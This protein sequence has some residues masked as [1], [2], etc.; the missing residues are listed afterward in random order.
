M[1]SIQCN[2]CKHGIHY[3]SIP[4]GT[5]YRFINIEN[6]QIICNSKFEKSNIKIDDSNI[7]PKLYRSDTIEED[8]SDSIIKFWICPFCGTIIFFDTDGNVTNTFIKTNEKPDLDDCIEGIIFDDYSWEDLTDKCLPDKKLKD[9]T[10]TAHIEINNMFIVI[11]YK[12]NISIY[13]NAT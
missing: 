1:S 10:P 5:E 3:H 11:T 6:W 13:K 8:F 12:E 9:T 4:N 2:V 7:Y